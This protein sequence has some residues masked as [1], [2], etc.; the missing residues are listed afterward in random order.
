[1]QRNRSRA[2]DAHCYYVSEQRQ[3]RGHSVSPRQNKPT[4]AKVWKKTSTRVSLQTKWSPRFF[5][6]YVSLFCSLRGRDGRDVLTC[7]NK[8][9]TDLSFDEVELGVTLHTSRA[10]E[11]E[12]RGKTGCYTTCWARWIWAQQQLEK[13]TDRYFFLFLNTVDFLRLIIFKCP[14]ISKILSLQLRRNKD[15]RRQF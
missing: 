8:N 12:G 7:S 10:L 1:M 4:E 13:W 2:T 11:D 14:E 5:S 15:T 6:F 9:N 3:H